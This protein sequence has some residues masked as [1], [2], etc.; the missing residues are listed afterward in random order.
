MAKFK[1]LE[2]HVGHFGD[3]TGASGIIDEVKY[4]RRFIKKIYEI[5]KA[6]NVPATYYEDRTSKNKTDNVNHLISY[7]NQDSGG[8]IVS[9]HLNAS[10]S[11]VSESIGVETL[12]S[13]QK[14][15]AQQ[16]TDAICKVS[17][18]KNRGA[19]YRDNI[20]VLVRTKEP[21][22]LIEFGFVN[23][24]KDVELMD[25]HFDAI[26]LEVAKVLAP[27]AGGSIKG[28][29]TVKPQQPTNVPDEVH[30]KDWQWAIENKIT[31]GTNPQG[32][33]TRQQV[34]TMIRRYNDNVVNK[35]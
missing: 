3:G 26:C 25:K 32:P 9:G 19:K 21:A 1:R 16:V 5:C 17:G 35:K 31:D 18:M 7:H 13:T 29:D 33:V 4:A 30:A 15:V 24:K 8:F 2:F 6:N 12:Y 11:I 23:S 27:L 34:A 20:G 22:V 28:G 10:G 14:V